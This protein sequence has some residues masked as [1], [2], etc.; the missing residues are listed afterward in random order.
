MNAT[1]SCPSGVTAMLAYLGLAL[2][3]GA[4]AF[5]PLS[6]PRLASR[7][8]TRRVNCRPALA[9]N[10]QLPAPTVGSGILSRGMAA[11]D[12]SGADKTPSRKDVLRSKKRPKSPPTEVRIMSAYELMKVH[13]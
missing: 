8:A 3:V 1:L 9:P 12:T 4:D 13:S 2:L 5:T 6:V 10:H 11:D 7:A